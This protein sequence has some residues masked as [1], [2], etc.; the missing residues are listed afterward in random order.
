MVNF[1]NFKLTM[2]IVADEKLADDGA[3]EILTPI[4]IG[5]KKSGTRTQ[6]PPT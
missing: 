2:G 5:P 6:K 3:M 4:A 1:D